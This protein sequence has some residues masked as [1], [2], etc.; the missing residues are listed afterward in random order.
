MIT[1]TDWDEAL[2]AWVEN[3]RA[4]L[5][6]PPTREEIV[7]FLRGELSAAETTRVRALLVYYPELT[8]L[9]TERIEKPRV[10][11]HRPRA[12]QVYAVAATLV[13]ALLSTEVLVERARNAEPAAVSSHYTFSPSLTRSG[14]GLPYELAAGETRYLLTIIPIETPRNREHEVEIARESRVVWRADDVHPLDGAF[15]ID[16]PGR[17]LERGTYTLRV[18]DGEQLVARY[19]LQVTP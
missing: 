10:I 7:A 2:D 13:I 16:V 19:T 1:N 3:E 5:G 18:R 11:A 4:R 9:L 17:F 15:V 12:L 14:A 8:P 6:G